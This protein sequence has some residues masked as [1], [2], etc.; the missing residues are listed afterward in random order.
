MALATRWLDGA[1]PTIENLGT[2]LWLENEFWRRMEMSVANGIA[3]A[4]KN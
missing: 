3:Q 1:E 2:A 4:F